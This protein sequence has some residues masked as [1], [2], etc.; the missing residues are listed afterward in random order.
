MSA[1]SPTPTVHRWLVGRLPPDVAK[2]LDR[3]A[4]T[5][6]VRHIA[7]MPDVHLAEDVCVGTVVATSRLIYPQAVG[8][9]IGCGMAAV[10]FD[11][12]AEVLAEERS[13]ANLLHALHRSVRT[14]RRLP[15]S[16][17]EGPPESIASRTLSHPMLE[18]MKG[19]DGRVEF[20]TLGRG[21]HFL[22][23]QSDPDGALWLMVH[24]GSRAMGQAIREHHLRLAHP[25]ASGLL[26][27][28]AETE[29]GQ[30]Y[31]ADLEWACAHAEENRR[32]LVALAAAAMDRLFGALPIPE[33][34]IGCQH[35]HVRREVLGDC[36]LWVHR[37]GAISAREGEPGIIPGS[38]GSSSFHVEGRGEERSLSSS[39]HGAGRAR[40][41]ADA[42]R[43]ISVRQLH[44][45]M[46]GVWFDHRL[47]PALR[48]EAPS[49][50]KDIQ[51][52]M[53]AQRE[54]TRIVRR[55]EPVCLLRQDAAF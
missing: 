18:K 54:L 27:L 47:A 42:A 50:Y 40:S 41:R 55:L 17:E 10:R 19:R 16:P 36:E 45:E 34:F 39:S 24:S 3:L 23:F 38:M 9:D 30:A 28:H 29:A 15:G 31:L 7:V 14:L 53:R 6:D 43:S 11:C 12:A 4:T 13:A 49:A 1:P 52:V 5:E 25:A 46:R 44:R 2:A 37:K 51:E 26:F 22:E 33:S 48:D 8:G 20:G 32:A 35:N 21:N